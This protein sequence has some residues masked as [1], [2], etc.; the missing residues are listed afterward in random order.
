MIHIFIGTKAQFIKMAPIM[1]ELDRRGI[2]F[3][4]IDTGQHAGITKD[5][6][7]QFGLRTPDVF[8]R[9]ERTNISRLTEAVMW[10]ITNL[11]TAGL[12]TDEIWKKIFR[13][14]KG[15]CLIHGDTLT[16]FFSL[17]YAKRCAL[18]VAHVEAGLRS[19]HILDPF[20]EEIIR[21]ITMQYSD[22]LFAPSEWAYRNLQE[23]NFGEK[24]IDAGGNTILD[25]L[26]YVQQKKEDADSSR[27]PY[28][29]AT[30]HR[31]ETIFSRSRMAFV[32]ELL[33]RI[34][35]DRRVLFVLHEPTKNQLQRFGLQNKI[36]RLTSVELLP[37]QP[38]ISFIQLLSGADFIV[39]DGGSIQEESYFLNI[40]CLIM[41]MK[42][43]RM[44]GIGA[45]AVL[46]E[47]DRGK[48]DR[49]FE[50]FPRLKRDKNNLDY[51]HPSRTI[52]DHLM[53]FA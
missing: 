11:W 45:N 43:E 19:Y 37:L 27:G 7:G 21:R 8:L 36:E 52:V 5:L 41:R 50:T 1:Q 20:P 31:F 30:I 23:M 24:S 18:K 51:V 39:T 10:T 48:I 34:A 28:V 44:E 6:P 12:R 38:Y 9:K 25:T 32:I 17:L 47:F 2:C 22:L 40:P 35:R 3:N 33:E 42:T 49:F 46:A 29:V 16:T 4:F 15:I 14:E 53:P 26:R 13:E